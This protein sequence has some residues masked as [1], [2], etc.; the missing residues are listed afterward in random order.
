MISSKSK[1]ALFGSVISQHR[2]SQKAGREQA[3][4][5]RFWIALTCQRFQSGD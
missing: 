4:P 1:V 2:L 3:L 5:E